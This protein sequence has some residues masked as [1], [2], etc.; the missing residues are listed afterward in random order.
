M[1]IYVSNLKSTF[2]DEDLRQLFAAYGEVKS[3]EIVNDSFN[4]LSRG[5]GYV[6]IGDEN[7]AQ[8]AISDLHQKVID[9]LTISVKETK[10]VNTQKGSYKVGDGSF[11]TYRFKKK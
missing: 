3:A 1:N 4:G 10:P 2:N 7:A 6:E 8:K 9:G 11:A 5:F